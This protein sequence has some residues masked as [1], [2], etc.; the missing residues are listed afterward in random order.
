ME[1][2]TK[3]IGLILRLL[4]L[5]NE[6]MNLKAIVTPELLQ[7]IPTNLKKKKNNNALN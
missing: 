5:R 4:I 1:M 6:R 3:A 2:I 7:K